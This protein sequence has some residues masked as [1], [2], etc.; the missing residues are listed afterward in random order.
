MLF[1]G[2]GREWIL[3]DVDREAASGISSALGVGGLLARVLVAREASTADAAAEFLAAG[4]AE[5]ADARLLPDAGLVVERV[6]AA[7]EKRERVVVHGHDDADGVCATTI[8][9]EALRQLGADP[10]TYIPDRRREGHGLSRGEI[11]ML[12]GDSVNLI[13]TVD[14]C[15]SE[16]E[17]IAH[18]KSLGMDT[19]VTDHHEIPPALPEEASAVVNPKLSDSRFPYRYMAGVGVSLRVSQLLLDELGGRFRGE[20]GAAWVGPGW[21]DEAMALA[22]VG[23]VADKVPLT[24]ENRKIVARGL[25]ALPRTE[26]PG[27]RSML[28]ESRLWGTDVEPSDVQEYLGPIFGRVSD[29]A[30][31]NEALTSLLSSDEREAEG[32]VR[33]LVAERARWR[34]AASEAWKRVVQ[35]LG[36]LRKPGDAVLVVQADVPIEVM[37]YVTTRLADESK[38][39]TIV[40]APKGDEVM[41]EARGPYGFDL[42]AAFRTMPELFLGYGGHPRAAGFSARPSVVPEFKRRMA[43]FAAENPPQPPPRQ[44]DAAAA[45][46]DLTVEAARELERLRPFGFG[47]GRAVLLARGVTSRSVESAAGKGVHLGTPGRLGRTP[48][49]VVYRVRPAGDVVL[50]NIIETVNE[51]GTE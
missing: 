17:L 18:A 1:R 28:V 22:A 32:I 14:S 41:A 35:R 9:V 38:R 49:D 3:S 45:I 37:G 33:R 21:L 27:L 16:R 23:S 44:I 8:M 29:G 13:I 2:A 43:E 31:G 7:L 34:D 42:V 6:A 10:L 46:D 25:S 48:R 5:L 40:I 4:D 30:G 51:I 15:V 47:N 20:G 36:D 39:P 26:R 24:G 50:I 12:A 19:I 11:D